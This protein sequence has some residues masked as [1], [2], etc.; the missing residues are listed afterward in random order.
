MGRDKH[1]SG[2]CTWLRERLDR[3]SSLVGSYTL[4][5]HAHPGVVYR[6]VDTSLRPADWA[7]T[8]RYCGGSWTYNF[9]TALAV[10]GFFTLGAYVFP[11]DTR[12]SRT[13]R[14][15]F[16][17]GCE[18]RKAD[19]ESLPNTSSARELSPPKSSNAALGRCLPFFFKSIMNCGTSTRRRK[20]ANFWV[21]L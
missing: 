21:A 8:V 12:S 5:D 1:R 9:F 7:A 14:S 18:L 10:T 19:M 20:L 4:R 2:R 6:V 3:L 13:S 15:L 17:V 11:G 16:A